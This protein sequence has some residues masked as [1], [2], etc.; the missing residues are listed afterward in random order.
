MTAVLASP[1]LDPGA[2]RVMM[3]LPDG[4][5]VA[6]IVD[7]TLPGLSQ[8]DRIVVRT[9][10]VTDCGATVIDRACWSA[11]RPKPGVRVVIRVVPGKDAIR[12]V[13]TIVVSIAAVAVGG[14]WGAGL[15]SALGVSTAVGTAMVT[16]GVSVIG[17][18]LINALIP[19]ARPKEQRT[20][21]SFAIN[22]WQNRLD[23]DGAVPCV[24]G[25][26]RYAPPFAVMPHTEIVGDLQYVRAVFN[27]GYGP[28]ELS[29]YQL[30]DTPLSQFTGVEVED[31]SGVAGDPALSLYPTQVVEEQIGVDLTR[32]KPRDDR[33][34]V[35]NGDPI[36]TPVVRVTGADADGASVIFAFPAGLVRV[37]NKGDKQR[38]HVDI[39]IRQRLSGQTA[40]HMVERLSINAAKSEAFYRQHSWTFPSRGRWEIEV[41][42]MTGER[43]ETTTSDRSVWLALQTTRPEYPISFG[44]PLA[45]T[46]VRIKA[47][48]QLSGA[49]DNL[50]ARVARRCLD[51]DRTARQWVMRRTSNPASL[52]RYILQSRANPRPV[53]DAGLDL[54]QLQDWH[55]YCRLKGLFYD[56]VLDDT[57]M[58]LRDA[59]AEVAAAGRATPRHDGVRWGVTIDRPQDL[60]VDHIS[61]RNSWNF[62]SS[63]SYSKRPDGLRVKFQD[64]T[65]DY[66]PAERIVPWPGHTG[67]VLLTEALEL[68][69]KTDP[70]EIWREA[71][72]RMYEIEERPD[73]YEVMQDGPIR[74]ATRGDMVMLSHDVLDD[75][76]RAAQVQRVIGNLIHL[77]EAVTIQ[78]G[79]DYAIRFR[80]YSAADTVGQSHIRT[81][82]A[83]PGETAVLTLTGTGAA[84]VAGDAV[85]FGRAA[86]LTAP[87]IVTAV[88]TTEDQACLIRLIDAAPQIDALTDAD[89]PPAWSG[90]IGAEIDVEPQRPPTPRF[91]SLRSTVTATDATLIYQIAPGAGAVRTARYRLYH[92][93]TGTTVWTSATIPAASGGGQISGYAPDHSIDIYAE[94]ISSA[95][96]VSDASSVVSVVMGAGRIAAPAALDAA[97]VSITALFGGALIQFGT[98]ADP[99]IAQVQVYRSASP[100]LD[101]SR[102][103]AGDPI[104]VAAR[105][106]YSMALGDTSRTN[107]LTGGTMTQS[108]AWST[109]P[110]WTIADGRASHIAGQAGALSQPVRLRSGR[111]YRIGYI[112]SGTGTLRAALTGGADRQGR[113]QS[114]D[115]PQYD[116][117]LA[118]EGNVRF[119]LQA[120]DDF[121]GAVDDVVLFLE[122]SPCLRSGEH[123]IWLE[124][125]NSDGLAGPL[126]GPITIEVI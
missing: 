31:R 97:S 55:V 67:P 24:L 1:L 80:S 34:E 18:L 110:G 15:A 33:G 91:V 74:V 28:L 10:L 103:A 106:S 64:A 83:E 30:G 50:S 59:L 90:R 120:G 122:T 3:N 89:T 116:R 72:R 57:G 95:G 77:D 63:R 82:S 79:Q 53:P 104:N 75:V 58:T 46:A 60:I 54:E 86:T 4:L 38:Q 52:Y 115:G 66:K 62:R 37:D 19:P 108:D 114:G 69:G 126:T 123:H 119:E 85:L 121:S 17:N 51:W 43:D 11:V 9:A 99:N 5:T 26:L 7:L 101:R 21:N 25:R 96:A 109:G 65:H 118:A 6:Q 39:R 14:L 20:A 47:T 45:L 13:L 32:P 81:V 42:R 40:W 48:H 98:G 94:A 87:M 27:F 88:E 16:F 23:P 49:L 92:R 44:E 2:G 36:E 61:P 124:P 111:W 68:P 78:P 113:L 12:S 73:S 71:R 105:Q 107:L 8:S 56:R 70:A 41:T 102:D 117:I 112:A 84:P 125:L 29:D 76:Q 22:G 93:L 35:I 100:T